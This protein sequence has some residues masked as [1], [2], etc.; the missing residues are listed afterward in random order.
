MPATL[1]AS[2]M[3]TRIRHAGLQGYLL[4]AKLP[5][6]SDR[7]DGAIAIVFDGNLRVLIH[8]ADGGDVVFE[9]LVCALPVASALADRLLE[10]VARHAAERSPALADCLVLG[11]SPERLL[12]QQRVAAEASSDEFETALTQYLNALTH[13]RARTG[14][15]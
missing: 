10:D 15:L 9:A 8:P 2:T 12:L 13:W 5:V 1:K 6:S 11:G 4:R 7:A 14:A 3:K